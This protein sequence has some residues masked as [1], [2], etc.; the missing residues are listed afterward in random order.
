[1][2]APRGDAGG[3]WAALAAAF[4]RPLRRQAAAVLLLF[5]GIDLAVAGICP[6]VGGDCLYGLFS[7]IVAPVMAAGLAGT[8]FSRALRVS[9]LG[10]AARIAV[11]AAG[12]LGAG[13]VV[14]AGHVVAVHVCNGL[15]YG[16]VLYKPRLLGVTLALAGSYYAALAAIGS[17]RARH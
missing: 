10:P 8:L 4:P 5:A 1:V 13:L 9:G 3:V 11:L 12:A 15:D 2:N 17:I 6:L 14:G 7:L 16:G